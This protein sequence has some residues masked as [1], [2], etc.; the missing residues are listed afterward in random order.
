MV[1]SD[2]FLHFMKNKNFLLLNS[3][4]LVALIRSI[5]TDRCP[6]MIY[7]DVVNWSEFCSVYDVTVI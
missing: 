3:P 6:N 2:N 7:F 1:F 5:T 4:K